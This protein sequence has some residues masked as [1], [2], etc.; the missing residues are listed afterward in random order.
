MFKSLWNKI[1]RDCVHWKCDFS[2]E[3]VV[4]YVPSCN[5]GLNNEQM[6]S[7][8]AAELLF[9]YMPMHCN[10]NL[11]ELSSGKKIPFQP[12]L[13]NFGERLLFRKT[14]FQPSFSPKFKKPVSLS[15]ISELNT[16]WSSSSLIT[17]YPCKPDWEPERNWLST[18]RTSIRKTR[19]PIV[20]IYILHCMLYTGIIIMKPTW[21]ATNFRKCGNLR[22][23]DFRTIYLCNLRICDLRTHLFLRTL[24]FRKY[25]IFLLTNISVKALIQI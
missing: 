11:S 19:S 5:L 24:N 20:H 2:A 18:K 8:M 14:T 22:I 1:L 23:R 7:E 21:Q 9:R 4:F 25:I 15:E 17:F 13:K 16:D 3:K 6:F 10:T 12:L